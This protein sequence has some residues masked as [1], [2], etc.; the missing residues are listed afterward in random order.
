[1]LFRSDYPSCPEIIDS[2]TDVI[3]CLKRIPRDRPLVSRSVLRSV[4]FGICI[5][6]CLTDNHAQREFLRELLISQERES[7]GNIGE[8]RKLMEEV[9]KRREHSQGQPVNWRDVMRDS[10]R[11]LLLLV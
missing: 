6:G 8:V 11:E 7:V 2:V 5:A 4:V 1:M 10:Q 9:W 3:E